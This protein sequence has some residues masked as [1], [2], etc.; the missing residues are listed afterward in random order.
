MV[1]GLRR[2]LNAL[3]LVLIMWISLVLHMVFTVFVVVSLHAHP[4]PLQL[5]KAVSP[6]PAA[7]QATG[8]VS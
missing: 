1:Q 6:S 2:W 3:L 5:T 7:G 8:R 4:S